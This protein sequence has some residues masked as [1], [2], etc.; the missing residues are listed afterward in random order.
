MV[1]LRTEH[2][3]TRFP[4]L[5]HPLPPT[6]TTTGTVGASLPHLRGDSL[7][8]PPRHATTQVHN[9][10]PPTGD[11]G[12]PAAGAA[13]PRPREGAGGPAMR[14]ALLQLPDLKQCTHLPSLLS[15]DFRLS[16]QIRANLAHLN[17]PCGPHPVSL[18]PS[19]EYVTSFQVE[20]ISSFPKHLRLWYTSPLPEV[21][22]TLSVGQATEQTLGAEIPP[23]LPPN[24]V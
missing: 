8:P 17:W 1:F 20:F 7:P 2:R 12:Q 24:E 13:G 9:T 4:W 15:H 3:E 19:P 21:A 16:A 23:P 14:Q 22:W 10:Q 18:A 6:Q 11:P 5:C